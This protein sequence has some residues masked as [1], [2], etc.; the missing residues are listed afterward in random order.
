MR[1]YPAFICALSIAACLSLPAN[2]TPSDLQRLYS[3]NDPETIRNGVDDEPSAAIS[4]GAK[5]QPTPI[6]GCALTTT[7]KPAVDMT[8]ETGIVPF[9]EVLTQAC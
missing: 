7:G 5:Q 4:R 9:D 2:A 3:S 8:R 6:P 1:V